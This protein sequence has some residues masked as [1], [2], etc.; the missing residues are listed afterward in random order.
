M[1]GANTQQQ[2]WGFV[3]LNSFKLTC[4]KETLISPSGRSSIL[5]GVLV[6]PNARPWYSTGAR[7]LGVGPLTQRLTAIIRPHT[8]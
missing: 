6:V 7:K 3:A 1:Q 4:I 2:K 8:K 5:T